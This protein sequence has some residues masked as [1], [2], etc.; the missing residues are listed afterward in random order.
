MYG[1]T[2]G[3][4]MSA[5]AAKARTA[6]RRRSGLYELARRGL[7]FMQ[8]FQRQLQHAIGE[9]VRLE[10]AKPLLELGQRHDCLGHR[11]VAAGTADAVEVLA[12]ELAGVLR[13]SQVPDRHH[14]RVIDDAGD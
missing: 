4:V 14:Q 8:E 5:N 1:L 11:P 7:V 13:I 9:L 12:D 3:M 10:I 6:S 2:N